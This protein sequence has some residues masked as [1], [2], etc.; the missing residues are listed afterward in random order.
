MKKK[1][2]LLLMGAISLSSIYSQVGINT[3]N[4]AGIFHVDPLNDTNGINNTTDDVVIS[5]TGNIGVGTTNPSNKL[6]IV[7]TGANTGL[8]LPNGASSGNVLVSDATGNASWQ[9]S[10]IQFQTMVT[11]SVW[12]M[13]QS[14]NTVSGSNI[15]N[16]DFTKMNTLNSIVV[17]KV[18]ATF[19]SSY[20]WSIA[21]QNY[22]VP[23]NGIY[24][25]GFSVYFISDP[26]NV[27]QNYRAY[28]FLNGSM[29][30][31]PGIISVTDAGNHQASYVMGLAYLSKDDILDL[32]LFSGSGYLYYWAGTGHTFLLIESL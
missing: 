22:R 11:S 24:R 8:H 23:T 4:P 12:N 10:A 3:T 16:S 7:T 29:L 17:D 19:G 25:I 1:I 26:T 5:T 9:S 15:I 28:I 20:G 2:L 13:S 18:P 21:N 14:N 30:L 31:D 6:S 27:S 32:R